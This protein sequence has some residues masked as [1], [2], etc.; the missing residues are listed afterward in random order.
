[1]A[2]IIHFHPSFK[3]ANR[4]VKPLIMQ[5]Q[6]LGN[7]SKLVVSEETTMNSEALYFNFKINFYNLIFFPI[8]I[9]Q[10]YFFIKKLKPSAVFVHNSTASLLPLLVSKLLKIKHRIYYNHGVPYVSYRGILR[11]LLFFL[12]YL[13]CKFSTNLITVSNEMKN[14]LSKFNN[15]EISII[16]FGSA[17]G[18]DLKS[19]KKNNNKIKILKNEKNF[20]PND[21]LVL[22]VGRPHE[23]KGFKI[24]IELWKKFFKKNNEKLLMCGCN[25]EDIK[26]IYGKVPQ[27]IIPMG[28]VKDI[29]KI[30]QI[31]DMLILPSMHEGFPYAILEAMASNCVVVANDVWGIK[32]LI[33]NGNNGFLIV[34]NDLEE[35]ARIINLL[36]SDINFR[37]KN[38][39]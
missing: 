27:N 24:S 9:I 22:Y 32:S 2:N 1:M 4:F 18:I 28:F 38:E 34:K 14:I 16:N 23:R 11:Y 30:Y 3:M 17:C 12:E 33:K 29:E 20:K 7:K 13:N 8:R 15:G 31:S 5:E 37:Q 10:F 6:R 19:F 35:Y 39:R 21:F 26:K 36:I 25:S